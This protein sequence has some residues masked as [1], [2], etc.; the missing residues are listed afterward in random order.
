MGEG[1]INGGFMI[2]EPSV[3]DLIEGDETSLEGDVLE[4][5]SRDG[6]LAAYRHG[7]FWQCVD[8]LRELRY[9]RGLWESGE[10]PW[11]TWQ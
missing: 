3:L 4:Q 7:S 5:L 10:R 9:L 1:W 6:E 8:T 2:F 11:V